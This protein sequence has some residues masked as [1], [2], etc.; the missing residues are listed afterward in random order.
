[1]ILLQ[2]DKILLLVSYG[3][4]QEYKICVTSVISVA[5]FTQNEVSSLDLYKIFAN[6][7]WSV[8]ITGKWK[9]SSNPVIAS[10][11]KRWH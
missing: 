10:A 7:E 6:F 9:C 3:G 11:A 5:R 2:G 8:F 1:M 4:D